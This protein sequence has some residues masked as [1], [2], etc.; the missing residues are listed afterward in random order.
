MTTPTASP[1]CAVPRSGP[2]LRA[3]A[4]WT[5]ARS[6]SGGQ[7][8][9]ALAGALGGEIRVAADHQ[10]LAGEVGGGYAGHVALV[11]Q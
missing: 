3:T 8:V 6:L 10:P 5:R 11:E 1:I 7:Q 2:R 9:F 4:A